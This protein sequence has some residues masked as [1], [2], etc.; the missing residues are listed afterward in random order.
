MKQLLLLAFIANIFCCGN[1]FAQSRFSLKVNAG[2]NASGF[3]NLKNV[4]TIYSGY[5]IVADINSISNLNELQI[6]S[7]VYHPINTNYKIGYFL[8][9]E[10]EYALKN[11][12]ALSLSAGINKVNSSYTTNLQSSDKDLSE[13]IQRNKD[14]EKKL[15]SI[16][17][18][19]IH[20]K[21]INV[22]K[23]FNKFTV[24][25]GPSIM[26]LVKNYRENSVIFTRLSD[27]KKYYLNNQISSDNAKFLY[28]INLSL[29][30]NLIPKTDFV[31]STQKLFSSNLMSSDKTLGLLQFSAG[32]SY[33]IL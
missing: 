2:G 4:N 14:I 33:K 32:L 8:E 22:A 30:Y 10:T 9:L 19:Y 28:G 23:T 5:N 21:P 13:Y 31:V 26:F 6:E 7:S 11:N 16:S 3:Q 29:K 20:S 15:G 17:S 12:W 24:Q 27:N 18:L 25:G 1:L